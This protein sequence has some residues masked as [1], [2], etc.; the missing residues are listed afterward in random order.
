MQLIRIEKGECAT[1]LKIS[2][3][4]QAVFRTSVYNIKELV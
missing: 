3:R 4:F 1:E 2:Y